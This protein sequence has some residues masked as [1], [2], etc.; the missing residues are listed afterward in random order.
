MFGQFEILGGFAI[1]AFIIGIVA[2]IFWIWMLIDCVQNSALTGT[3]KVIWILVILFLHVL[4]ALIYYFVGRGRK[5][6]RP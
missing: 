2:T 3:D 5:T 6:L 1:L 4:G